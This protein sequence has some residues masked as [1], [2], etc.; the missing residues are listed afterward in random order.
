MKLQQCWNWFFWHFLFGFL[1]K[2]NPG[3]IKLSVCHAICFQW[4]HDFWTS[5]SL[6]VIL[7]NPRHEGP[8][9]LDLQISLYP[10]SLCCC[11]STAPSSAISSIFYL[12]ATTETC[13]QKPTS[14]K[15]ITPSWNDPS[16]KARHN[17]KYS[18]DL[19]EKPAGFYH[20]HGW[21]LQVAVSCSHDVQEKAVVWHQHYH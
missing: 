20:E 5:S 19:R 16:S 21:K 9:C 6:E 17:K 8:I 15:S 12:W 4:N 14:S 2:G 7:A 3:E 1:S 10:R 11:R 13:M 18:P